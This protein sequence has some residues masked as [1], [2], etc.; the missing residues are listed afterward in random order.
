MVNKGGSIIK[1]SHILLVIILLAVVILISF[2]LEKKDTQEKENSS[3]AFE[4]YTLNSSH[5]YSYLITYEGLNFNQIYTF[6]EI[7]NRLNSSFLNRTTSFKI[8]QNISPYCLQ[9]TGEDWCFGLNLWEKKKI[10]IQYSDDKTEYQGLFN[11]AE[12]LC[13]ELLHNNYYMDH[14]IIYHQ[15]NKLVCYQIK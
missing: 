14:D 8:V 3:F 9:Y 6:Q 15:G 10:I 7:F 12:I 13:H 5:S 2:I 1:N 4:D 11:M